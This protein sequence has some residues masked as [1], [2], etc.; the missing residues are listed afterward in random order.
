MIDYLLEQHEEHRDLIQKVL[1]DPGQFRKFR[2]ALIHH[3]NI[4]EEILF[5][6]LLSVGELEKEISHAW[7]EHA[8]LMDKIKILDGLDSSK[9]SWMDVFRDLK[10][11][12]LHHLEEEENHL[13]PLIMRKIHEDT[14]EDLLKQCGV[15]E[16]FLSSN[17]ILY[18]TTP[19]SHDSP[20]I[21]S[22][23]L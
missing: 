2:S 8:E 11:T 19:G 1:R 5:E 7:N 10:T 12:H 21:K 14:L 17:E 4:E 3:V 16:E 18:P 13:F 9:P 22:A 20:P 23:E 15:Q 6:Y